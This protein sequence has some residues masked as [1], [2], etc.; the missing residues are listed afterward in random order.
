MALI[1][2]LRSEGH[3]TDEDATIIVV[4][5]ALNALLEPWIADAKKELAEQLLRTMPPVSSSGKSDLEAKTP[6]AK[7]GR[8]AREA[9]RRKDLPS[10]KNSKN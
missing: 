8:G 2:V 4:R 3:S 1:K 6:E 5:R 7:R 9:E 10:R